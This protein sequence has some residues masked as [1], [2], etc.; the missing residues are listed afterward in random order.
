MCDVKQKFLQPSLPCDKRETF[1]HGSNCNEAIQLSIVVARLDRAIQYAAACRLYL[2]RLSNTGS[3]GQ[4]GLRHLY[5]YL[6][7]YL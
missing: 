1:A 7:L 4:V 5:P 2:Q 3:P 6:Y